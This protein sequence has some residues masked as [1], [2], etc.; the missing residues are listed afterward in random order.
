MCFEC[1][2]PEQEQ[3]A[4]LMVAADQAGEADEDLQAHRCMACATFTGP[5]GQFFLVGPDE[6]ADIRRFHRRVW[7]H[8]S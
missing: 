4:F 7:S 2:S 5:G 6:I 8:R 1:G 3:N